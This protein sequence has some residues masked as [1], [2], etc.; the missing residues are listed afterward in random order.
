MKLP[1]YLQAF[2]SP[3]KRPQLKFYFGK[4][5]IGVPI[6]LPRKWVKNVEKP[7]YLK[8]VP[9][10]FGFCS[11]GLGWKTKYSST[12]YRFEHPAKWCFVAFNLQ[13]VLTFF[14]ENEDAYWES[15]LYYTFNTEGTAE[16]RIA[17]CRK[18]A[19]QNWTRHSSEGEEK[20][21]YY[22]LILK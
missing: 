11:C 5:K 1:L 17:Q 8:A 18:E 14:A 6:F 15:F 7:G 21:D 3:F 9:I 22:D 16:E 12:D 4:V 13:F 19:P 2:N 10:K 20:I